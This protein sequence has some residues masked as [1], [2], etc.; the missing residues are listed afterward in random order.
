MVTLYNE[1]TIFHESLAMFFKG[2]VGQPG[3]LAKSVIR[4]LAIAVGVFAL[5]IGIGVYQD[6]LGSEPKFS[7]PEADPSGATHGVAEKLVSDPNK[8][9]AADAALAAS[10]AASVTVEQGIVKFYFAPGKADLAP[11]A[12][13]AL[14][15]MVKGAS[16]GRKLVISGFHDATGDAARNSALARQRALAVRNALTALG[17]AGQQ[18]E[19]K[20]PEPTASSGSSADARRVE[21]S[22]Q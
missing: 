10:D 13:Q 12:G 3:A 21:I 11:G 20:K 2:N 18:I 15:D 1:P 7:Q 14:A 6:F 8:S 9:P 22:L 16:S 19:I 5:V 17:V 4:L